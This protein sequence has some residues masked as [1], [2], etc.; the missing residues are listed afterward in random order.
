MAIK[1]LAKRSPEG[2]LRTNNNEETNYIHETVMSFRSQTLMINSAHD[3][4]MADKKQ[5]NTW[6]TYPTFHISKYPPQNHSALAS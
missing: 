1:N 6:K 3:S 5:L 2:H 4:F